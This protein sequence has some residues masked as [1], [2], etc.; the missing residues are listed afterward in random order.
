MAI[1]DNADRV[2]ELNCRSYKLRDLDYCFYHEM[3]CY[4]EALER[5][6]EWE[7]KIR[8]VEAAP[9]RDLTDRPR[10]RNYTDGYDG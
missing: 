5:E 8:I 7:I 10:P 1:E 9:F 4:V 3:K 6:L 2:G